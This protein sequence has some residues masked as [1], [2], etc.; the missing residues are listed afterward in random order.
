MWK[1]WIRCSINDSKT[2]TSGFW[3]SFFATQQSAG[4]VASTTSPWEEVFCLD[5]YVI[6][7]YQI[8]MFI[9]LY[10]TSFCLV[11][12][13]VFYVAMKRLFVFHA[14]SI[15]TKAQSSWMSANL[16][17]RFVAAILKELRLAS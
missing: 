15:K 16:F 1:L 8:S 5:Y 17:F 13:F 11:G 7:L 6:A 9:L 4:F 2:R 3:N 14:S 10:Q 12:F